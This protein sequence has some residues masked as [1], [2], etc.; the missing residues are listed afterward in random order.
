M[1]RLLVCSE[2]DLPSTNMRDRL[3]SLREWEDMG[4][5]DSGCFLSCG[6][7]V[8]MTTPV[9]HICDETVEGRA[10]AFGVRPD[11]VTFMSRHTASSGIPTLTV[12][13]IGNYHDNRYGGRQEAL[14]RAC[15]ALM[16]DALRLISRLDDTGVYNVSFEVTHHGPWLEAPTFF[17]EIG[18]DAS[19]WGDVDAADILAR[20]LLEN[21]G[22][23]Y[24]SAV[25]FGGGHYA[26]R[27]SEVCL[28]YRVNFGHM[29]P[30]YQ[31]K[32]RDDEEV[33]RMVRMAAEATGTDMVYIHR[34]SMKRSEEGRYAELIA[35]AGFETV[36]SKDF[37]PVSG[38]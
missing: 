7:M 18:S 29:V 26:P 4:S 17:I 33:L 19:R 31:I 3:L 28:G 32:G 30:S 6:D 37:D 23:G 15:P 35:S 9:L 1:T 16:S 10:R 8:M 12:H 21:A 38:T 14:V 24:P 22:N 5:D 25:G 11:S 2:P 36:S 20:V 13:P 27:F 34:K